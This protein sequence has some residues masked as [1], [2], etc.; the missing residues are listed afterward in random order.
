MRLKLSFPANP[1]DEASLSLF[2]NGHRLFICLCNIVHSEI[3][4]VNYSLQGIETTI[5][6]S[7]TWGLD[8][9]THLLHCRGLAV[10]NRFLSGDMDYDAFSPSVSAPCVGHSGSFCRGRH[11]PKFDRQQSRHQWQ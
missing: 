1:A 11:H 2:L 7:V 5:V 8:L 9:A 10:P 4:P 3:A 6:I